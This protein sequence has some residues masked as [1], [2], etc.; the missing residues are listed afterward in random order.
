MLSKLRAFVKQQNLISPG[1]SIV[2]AVSGGADS[3]ALLWA[4]YLLKEEWQ[5]SL[6]AVP[7][8]FANVSRNVWSAQPATAA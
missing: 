8:A 5:L 6:S 2:C 4:L 1:D 3:I 7:S